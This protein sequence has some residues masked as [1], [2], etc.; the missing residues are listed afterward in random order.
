MLLR[1]CV[2]SVVFRRCA[3]RHALGGTEVSSSFQSLAC[4]DSL[5][6]FCLRVAA[7]ALLRSTCAHKADAP[8]TLALR[9]RGPLA[10]RRAPREQCSPCA[11]AVELLRALPR[12]SSSSPACARREAPNGAASPRKLS[13]LLTSSRTDQRSSPLADAPI[14]EH[15]DHTPK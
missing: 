12:G 15:V 5:D 2:R 4:N 1:C 13:P 3:R 10:R 6:S 7:S 9:A 14:R 8:R 11:A